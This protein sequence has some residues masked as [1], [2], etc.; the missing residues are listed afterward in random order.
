MTEP[1]RQWVVDLWADDDPALR[2]GRAGLALEPVL[3]TSEPVQDAPRR[4]EPVTLESTP[5]KASVAAPEE[6]KRESRITELVGRVRA[7]DLSAVDML[8]HLLDRQR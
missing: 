3:E 2:L 1:R 7:G 6:S 4:P 5:T 8:R